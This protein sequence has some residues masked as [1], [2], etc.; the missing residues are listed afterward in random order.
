MSLLSSQ[1]V[2]KCKSCHPVLVEM[3][4]RKELSVHRD[5]I[6]LKVGRVAGR[7]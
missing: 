1:M 4:S 3:E 6:I 5:A 2:G 7:D